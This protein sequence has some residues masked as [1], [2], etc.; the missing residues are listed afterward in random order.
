MLYEYNSEF[1]LL[2]IKG[3]KSQVTKLGNNIVIIHMIL[4]FFCSY[5]NI[6]WIY[7]NMS[8]NNHRTLKQI[9]KLMININ[10]YIIIINKQDLI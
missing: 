7:I 10:G 8:E 3:K 4:L 9:K 5:T 6:D 1:G 2:F